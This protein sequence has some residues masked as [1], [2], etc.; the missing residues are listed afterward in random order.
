[1]MGSIFDEEDCESRIRHNQG[2]TSRMN[3]SQSGRRHR[4]RR[5]RKGIGGLP[6]EGS[7]EGNGW[8]SQ[9]AVAPCSGSPGTTCNDNDMQHTTT[10]HNQQGSSCMSSSQRPR[11]QPRLRKSVGGSPGE[12]SG[13]GFGWASQQSVGPSSGSPIPTCNNESLG[14]EES[15]FESLARGV[16]LPPL[17]ALG[18]AH[19]FHG[20]HPGSKQQ[21]VDEWRHQCAP[22][23]AEP[24]PPQHPPPAPPAAPPISEELPGRVG[25]LCKDDG[26]LLAA[27]AEH[28]LCVRCGEK[29][30]LGIICPGICRLALV[31][32]GFLV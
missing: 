27:K 18:Q 28:C 6:G 16:G 2:E 3:S 29:P 19:A 23:D 11:H 7:G 26:P 15:Q 5:Q 21:A 30:M 14:V 8:A 4:K 13:D 17:P 24:T 22:V 32:G 31:H 12:A 10:R 1:M 9:Q 25:C 20:P